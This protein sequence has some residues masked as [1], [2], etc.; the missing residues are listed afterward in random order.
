[1]IVPYDLAYFKMIPSVWFGQ[2]GNGGFLSI[3]CGFL[4]FNHSH[5]QHTTTTWLEDVWICI[6]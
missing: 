6:L 1:M 4:A 2:D 5:Q 3:K